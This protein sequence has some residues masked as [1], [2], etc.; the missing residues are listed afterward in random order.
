MPGD[1]TGGTAAPGAREATLGALVD[2]IYP[3]TGWGP[4][5]RQLG[6][7]KVVRELATG[8][9]G[10]G[11][12]SYRKPPFAEADVPGLGWQWKATF[13]EALDYGLDVVEQWSLDSHGVPFADLPPAEQ[14]RAVA[15]L[16]DGTAPGFQLVSS[17]A[18][19]ELLYG[20]VFDA[21][22]VTPTSGGYSLDAVW[23]RLG[24]G[25]EPLA[26]APAG[27]TC[28]PGNGDHEERQ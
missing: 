25:R 7:V 27:R 15:A 24:I 19:F 8:P 16:E 18:F 17:R 21:L 11:Q 5:A 10:R 9:A 12:D 20:Y 13:L 26:D 3:E 23:D 14:S 1:I 22:F 28:P 6:V 2:Q 4:G